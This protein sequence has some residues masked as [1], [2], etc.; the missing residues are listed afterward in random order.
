MSIDS[1]V[2]VD[3][4]GLKERFSSLKS[5]SWDKKFWVLWMET[6]L[7]SFSHS[8]TSIHKDAH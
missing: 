6:W 2:N 4:S 7:M 5:S 3:N 1:G 8:S